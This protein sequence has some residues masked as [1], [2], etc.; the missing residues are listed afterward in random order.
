VQERDA[1]R[2]AARKARQDLVDLDRQTA[3]KAKAGPAAAAGRANAA[4]K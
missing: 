2:D 1:L 3:G 4:K